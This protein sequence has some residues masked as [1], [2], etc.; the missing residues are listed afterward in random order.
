MNTENR[1]NSFVVR[2][3]RVFDGAQVTSRA[4]VIVEQGVITAIGRDGS[5]PDRLEIFDGAGK[6]LLPGLIDSHTHAWGPLEAVLK[7]ALRFGV[8]TELDMFSEPTVFAFKALQA[9]GRYP[10]S[11][12][13]CSSGI[14]ASAPGGHGTEYG[15]SI[16][17][18]QR[19]EEAQAFV[20]AR[21]A[22]GSDY[23]KIIYEGRMPTISKETLSALVQA[24]HKRGKLALVH[25]GTLKEARD[26]IEV[27]A[28]GLA[29]LFVDRA[30]DRD[31]ANFVAEHHA[32][33][34]PTLTVLESACDLPGGST[35]VKDGR[36]G[37]YLSDFDLA[38][39]STTLPNW[40]RRNFPQRKQPWEP[41]Y[42]AAE[43]ALRALREENVPLLAGTDAPNPG[44]THGASMHRELELLVRGGLTPAEA[45]ASATSLPAQH[46]GLTDR[47]RVTPGLR[48]DL[49]LVEGD[50]TEEI[51]ETRAI[52][53]VWK[54]GVLVKRGAR[55]K[56]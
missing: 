23:I 7:K 47:G 32:F 11:A 26:A 14:A 43:H 10:D 48:A 37:P 31:F 41:I 12:D 36:L 21:I 22:E 30:P 2:D 34:V 9:E 40:R 49:L 20:D 45:L 39:L 27:G 3:V 50:P 53:A 55:R 44:T 29:H 5:I 25:I 54:A 8:T 51:T 17:T 4:T 13:L 46:F 19:P 38:M 15:F 6:T 52:V 18:I 33:V 16:P 24:A 42:A 1:S 28:D 35:L 56:A